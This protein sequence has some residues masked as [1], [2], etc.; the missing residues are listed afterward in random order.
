MVVPWVTFVGFQ[1]ISDNT[2]V[3]GLH[4]DL[5]LS[6]HRRRLARHLAVLATSRLPF[7]SV[8]HIADAPVLSEDFLNGQHRD[9]PRLRHGQCRSHHPVDHA[10]GQPSNVLK[11]H[12]AIIA[13]LTRNQGRR[14]VHDGEQT[15]RLAVVPAGITRTTHGCPQRP[16]RSSPGQVQP[17]SSADV[18][19]CG[20]PRQALLWLARQSDDARRTALR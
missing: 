7:V 1:S 12:V 19:S 6:C 4:N 15:G 14:R 17:G 11:P 10:W 13:W 5:R 3:H 20:T 18:A 16:P 8:P 2:H 9:A